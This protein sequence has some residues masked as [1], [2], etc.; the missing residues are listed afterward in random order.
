MQNF[1]YIGKLSEGLIR[2]KKGVNPRN[3]CG[4]INSKGDVVISFSYDKV[5]P[6]RNGIAKVKQGTE[7]CFQF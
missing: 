4:F 6:F 2:V 7:L 3:K 5:K 1:E